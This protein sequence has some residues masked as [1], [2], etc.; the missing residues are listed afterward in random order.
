[1]VL[2]KPQGQSTEVRD[3]MLRGLLPGDCNSCCLGREGVFLLDYFRGILI[4]IWLV[5]SVLRAFFLAKCLS[6]AAL[7]GHDVRQK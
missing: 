6:G 7:K 5:S 3:G 4:S 1:M 2:Q